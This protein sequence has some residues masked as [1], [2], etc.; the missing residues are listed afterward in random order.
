MSTIDNKKIDAT[1]E[2]LKTSTEFYNK[3]GAEAISIAFSKCAE[4]Y[5]AIEE[6]KSKLEANIKDYLVNVF[7]KKYKE[8]QPQLHAKYLQKIFDIFDKTASYLKT[9]SVNKILQD[10]TKDILEKS[11]SEI[12]A[13]SKITKKQLAFKKAVIKNLFNEIQTKLSEFAFAAGIPDFMDG[14]GRTTKEIDDLFGKQQ[15]EQEKQLE[16]SKNQ[17]DEFRKNNFIYNKEKLSAILGDNVKHIITSFVTLANTNKLLGTFNKKVMENPR[18]AGLFKIATTYSSLHRDIVIKEKPNAFASA[19][20][21]SLKHKKAWRNIIGL[22]IIPTAIGLGIV[23][24]GGIIGGAAF[25]GLYAASNLPHGWSVTTLPKN[26]EMWMKNYSASK[27]S[28]IGLVFPLF[29]SIRGSLNKDSESKIFHKLRNAMLYI[30][31]TFSIALNMLKAV[32]S[33]IIYLFKTVI[34]SILS[35]LNIRKRLSD[36]FSLL[37]KTKWLAMGIGILVGITGAAFIEVFV[38]R[39]KRKKNGENIENEPILESV[40]KKITSISPVFNFVYALINYFTAG[41]GARLNDK[42]ISGKTE[43]WSTVLGLEEEG[44]GTPAMRVIGPDGKV[45]IYVND[46]LAAKELGVNKDTEEGQARIKEFK[47]QIAGREAAENIM[48]GIPKLFS[49]LESIKRTKLFKFFTAACQKT[50]RAVKVAP[51]KINKWLGGIFGSTINSFSE[52]VNPKNTEYI[53]FMIKHKIE[54][55]SDYIVEAAKDIISSAATNLVARGAGKVVGSAVGRKIGM[56]AIKMLAGFGPVG[57]I[58]TAAI[59]TGLYLYNKWVDKAQKVATAPGIETD[60]IF[61]KSNELLSMLSPENQAMAKAESMSLENS[62]K[63]RAAGKIDLV[64]FNETMSKS[65]MTPSDNMI[66][67]LVPAEEGGENEST[68]GAI[69]ALRLQ[70]N[71][72]KILPNIYKFIEQ[73]YKYLTSKDGAVEDL[74]RS[75][76]DWD[77][78]YSNDYAFLYTHFPDNKTDFFDFFN[79]SGNFSKKNKITFNEFGSDSDKASVIAYTYAGLMKRLSFFNFLMN[80]IGLRKLQPQE[81]INFWNKYS[82]NDV[83]LKMSDSPSTWRGGAGMLRGINNL[84]A[85]SRTEVEKMAED[86][87]SIIG[88]MLNDTKIFE[89][90]TPEGTKKSANLAFDFWNTNTTT[91]G[92]VMSGIDWRARDTLLFAGGIVNSAGKAAELLRTGYGNSVKITLDEKVHRNIFNSWLLKQN[93]ENKKILENAYNTNIGFKKYFNTIID[94]YIGWPNDNYLKIDYK[95]TNLP[96]IFTSDMS[97]IAEKMLINL[98]NKVIETQKVL[99]DAGETISGLNL[100]KLEDSDKTYT[101]LEDLLPEG[102]NLG[103]SEE[104]FN[105]AARQV[106]ENEKEKSAA[107]ERMNRAKEI[108]NKSILSLGE[109]VTRENAEKIK[110]QLMAALS[111]GV[112]QLDQTDYV[113]PAALKVL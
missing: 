11:L 80:Y 104:D 78:K 32:M 93:P 27:S 28:L 58:A 107:I 5:R 89:S 62:M 37:F 29:D 71:I 14:A 99:D 111:I 41:E 103:I 42:L 47:E 85:A 26:V 69:T 49:Y 61:A 8:Y 36:L 52:L 10:F 67:F 24:F 68:N 66:K 17:T 53:N 73:E 25:A 45:K 46:D 1:T 91:A 18:F 101:D 64:E 33:P 70:L 55:W 83:I 106:A 112:N 21:Y 95:N 50:L 48:N 19:L 110:K 40:W 102:E 22:G 35:P 59:G 38:N 44:P 90:F 12:E 60:T 72:G 15:E 81:F 79:N 6:S 2:S 54:Y 92:A 77:H 20:Q 34:P 109:Y 23:G 108:T 100:E 30:G 84:T 96:V 39:F 75:M 43:L 97:L 7:S 65:T 16:E 113:Q 63:L 56:S 3:T 74:G 4:K 105:T 87:R 82:T 76:R 51:M 94:T 9:D 86:F 13:D 88:P 57:W 31:N 98:A